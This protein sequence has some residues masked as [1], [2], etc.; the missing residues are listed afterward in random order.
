MG[1]PDRRRSSLGHHVIGFDVDPPRLEG[2]DDSLRPGDPELPGLEEE[3]VHGRIVERQEVPQHVNL[4]PGGLHRELATAHHPQSQPVT[5]RHG[6]RHSGHGVV[7][8]QRNG[9]ETGRVRPADNFRRRQHPVGGS[10]MEVEVGDRVQ[11]RYPSSGEVQ[12]GWDRRNSSISRRSV[13]LA[14]ER[15]GLLTAW[16]EYRLIR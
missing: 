6:L 4:A 16:G 1:A 11:R 9:R 12:E 14:R 3:G 10:R 2:G 15:S 8:R 13:R 5:L 7:I